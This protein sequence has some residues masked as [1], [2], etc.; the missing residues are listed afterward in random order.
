[1]NNQ[2]ELGSMRVDSRELTRSLCRVR[3]ALPTLEKGRAYWVYFAEEWR[4]CRV[5]GRIAGGCYRARFSQSVIGCWDIVI[6]SNN[7]GGPLS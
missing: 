6:C 4:I 7:Y 1:M 2:D 5:V 3:E